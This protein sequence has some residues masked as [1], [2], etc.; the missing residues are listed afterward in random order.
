MDGQKVSA[1]PVIG[2]SEGRKAVVRED[3]G[4]LLEVKDLLLTGVQVFV[5][6]DGESL[7]VQ[8]TLEFTRVLWRAKPAVAGRV[9]PR[10]GSHSSLIGGGRS[11][12]TTFS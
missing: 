6:N 3:P 5:P 11:V 7:H 4:D 9:Q 12:G 1:I 2:E 8:P 10:V